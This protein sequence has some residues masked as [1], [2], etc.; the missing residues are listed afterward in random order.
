[1]T[2]YSADSADF[3][4]QWIFQVNGAGSW[5][6]NGSGP[7]LQVGKASVGSDTWVSRVFIGIPIGPL[8]DAIRTS[9]NNPANITAATLSIS[10]RGT[11]SC[12]GL[13]SHPKA[14]F[15]RATSA[16]FNENAESSECAGSNSAGIPTATTTNRYVF[17]D[18]TVSAGDTF[19][20]DLLAMLRDQYSADS[21]ST[22]LFVYVIA[23]DETD[24]T[25]RIAFNSRESTTPWSFSATYVTASTPA[26][27]GSLTP[28]NGTRLTGATTSRTFGGSYSNS[29][30]SA[31]AAVEI[32]VATSSHVDANG[33]LD[34]STVGVTGTTFSGTTTWSTTRTIATQT[35]GT[36]Y[37]WCCRTQSANG[38]YSA[39][40]AVKSWVVNRLPTLSVP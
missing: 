19:S 12:I 28:A 25:Q 26:T 40:S 8:V 18:A 23:Q 27:P 5:F 32:V 3:L 35:R 22:Y 17:D 11:H 37:Y 31:L 4:D 16:M 39:W 36:T 9:S 10:A 14:Y 6:R 34:T 24:A 20:I 7:R 33:K 13:G 15:E 30:G 1:M 2:T 38:V 21:H 29:D